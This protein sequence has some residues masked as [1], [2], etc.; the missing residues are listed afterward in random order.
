M[1]VNSILYVLLVVSVIAH[2]VQIVQALLGA[3]RY[4]VLE[5]RLEMCQIERNLAETELSTARIQLRRAL[6]EKRA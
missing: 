3:Q 6:G 1:N 5:Q 4:R 2:A